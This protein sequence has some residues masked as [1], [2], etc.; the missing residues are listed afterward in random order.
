MCIS[1]TREE[2]LALSQSSY[3][4][5]VDVCMECK[6]SS[7]VTRLAHEVDG[8]V[9]DISRFLIRFNEVRN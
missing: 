1:G 5:D 6:D 4:E 9:M 2:V 3:L 7:L 8:R